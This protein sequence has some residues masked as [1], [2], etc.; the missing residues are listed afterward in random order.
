VTLLESVGPIGVVG[1]GTMGG[2]IARALASAGRTVVAYD[3]DPGAVARIDGV[4][5]AS[6]PADV[7]SRC[8]VVVL[9]LPTPDVVAAVVAEIAEA[10]PGVT[11]LDTSTVGPDTSIDARSVLEAH[12]GRFADCPVLGRPSAVGAWTIPVGGEDDVVELA[13]AVLS[14]V[15]K[16]VVGVGPTG[17]AATLKVLSNLMLGVINAATAE[18]LVLAEEAGLDPQ[19]FVDTLVDSGAASVSGLFKDVAPRAVR[20][21]F[22]ATFSVRLMHKD[23][24]LALDLADRHAVD[25]PLGRAAQ[26]ANTRALDAGHGDEDSIAVIRPLRAA[27]RKR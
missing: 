14:P 11:V 20:D 5:P 23:N 8:R 21:D 16:R 26:A 12:G 27:V 13:R 7:A 2:P 17:A 24:A 1:V 4:E 3:A 25:V 19:V 10:A 9:S 6:S 22:A 18:V 15:A